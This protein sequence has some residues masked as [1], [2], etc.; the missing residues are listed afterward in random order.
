MNWICVKFLHFRSLWIS[1]RPAA[2]VI[3]SSF[4]PPM[5]VYGGNTV[6]LLLQKLR[7]YTQV[8]RKFTQVSKASRY[9]ATRNVRSWEMVGEYTGWVS[10]MLTGDHTT[11][12][13]H[14]LPASSLYV[15]SLSVVINALLVSASNNYPPCIS[16]A[17]GNTTGSVSHM[18]LVQLRRSFELNTL[19][20]TPY[21]PSMSMGARCG[22]FPTIMGDLIAISASWKVKWIL[23]MVGLVLRKRTELE[24]RENAVWSTTGSGSFGQEKLGKSCTSPKDVHHFPVDGRPASKWA[25]S[26]RIWPSLFP[27]KTTTPESR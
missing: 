20:L 27:N 12:T 21:K 3:F 17:L 7:K 11:I 1:L 2:C 14:Y 19:L 23:D 13:T 24:T 16:Y 26:G 6:P 4:G 8:L 22:R 10:T 18:V 5:Y 15:G 25:G 9:T